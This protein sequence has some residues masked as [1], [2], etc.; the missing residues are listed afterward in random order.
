MPLGY[1]FLHW[2]NLQQTADPGH[3]TKMTNYSKIRNNWSFSL[4]SGIR[5][6]F[7]P[8]SPT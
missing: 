5:T 2:Q 8:I 6:P 1:P 7:V 4:N 3:L